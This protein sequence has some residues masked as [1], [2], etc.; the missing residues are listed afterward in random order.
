MVRLKSSLQGL[1]LHVIG[2]QF[3]VKVTEVEVFKHVKLCSASQK[4]IKKSGLIAKSVYKLQNNY[5]S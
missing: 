3:G 2:A 4:E 5:N 1:T